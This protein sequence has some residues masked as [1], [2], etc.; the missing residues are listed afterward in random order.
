MRHL[1]LIFGIYLIACG[2]MGLLLAFAWSHEGD[3]VRGLFDLCVGVACCSL[4]IGAV[5]DARQ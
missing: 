1:Q 2:P 5:R 4:G 3:W